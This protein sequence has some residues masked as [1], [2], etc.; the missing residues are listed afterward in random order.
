MEAY[1]RGYKREAYVAIEGRD[2]KWLKAELWRDGRWVTLIS[3]SFFSKVNEK[4]RRWSRTDR[5]RLPVACSVALKRYN[6]L[7]G[8][9]DHFNKEL[10]KTYMQMGRCKQR[11]QRSLFLGWLLPAVGVVNV[12]TAFGE[13]VKVTW[14]DEALQMLKRSRGVATTTY[15]KWFQLRLGELL[16]HKGVTQ[17]SEANQGDEPHFLPMKRTKHWERPWVLPIPPGFMKSPCLWRDAVDI[18]KRPCAIPNHWDS[19][20]G[21]PDGWVGGGNP[22]GGQG[23]CEVCS[24]L[25][26][27]SGRSIHE[28]APRSKFACKHCRVILCRGCW[29]RY[30]HTNGGCVPQLELPAPSTAAGSPASPSAQSSTPEARCPEGHAMNRRTMEGTDLSCDKCDTDLGKEESFLSCAIC[31][32]DLCDSCSGC[33]CSQRAERAESRSD[34]SPDAPPPRPPAKATRQPSALARKRAAAK[35][36]R[37]TASATIAAG[38]K[39]AARNEQLASAR[40]KKFSSGG[41]GRGHVGGKRSRNGDGSC[42]RGR[43]RGRGGQ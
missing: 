18:Y 14:G 32:Y 37:Q 8:A 29:D 2:I 7:M 27:R 12:R 4:V 36:A 19:K 1:I 41:R 30:D 39:R 31:D 23:R 21:S 42:E 13:L 9:V 38:N 16:I 22:N 11:F 28:H 33:G 24:V 10:A 26:L 20:T 25:A 3:T 35:A 15:A 40:A 17:A 34:A 6:K 5:A 43:K